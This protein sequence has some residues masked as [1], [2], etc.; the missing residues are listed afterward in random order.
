MPLTAIGWSRLKPNKRE[1]YKVATWSCLPTPVLGN[2]PIQ[3]T[4]AD[5]IDRSVTLLCSHTT[6]NGAAASPNK[7]L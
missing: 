7:L 6:L 5:N 2:D 1:I 4:L 3:V